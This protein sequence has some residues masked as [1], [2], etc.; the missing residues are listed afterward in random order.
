MRLPFGEQ[1]RPGRR[2][3]ADRVEELGACPQFDALPARPGGAFDDDGPPPLPGFD[4]IEM[5]GK[6]ELFQ[7]R[8][9]GSLGP[10]QIGFV[11]VSHA[12]TAEPGRAR[13]RITHV[14]WD[15]PWNP[16]ARNG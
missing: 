10:C 15:S 9:H 14:T 5:S 1:G 6:P 8:A 11:R 12:S 2:V 16:S 4:G 7:E 3:A 13:E